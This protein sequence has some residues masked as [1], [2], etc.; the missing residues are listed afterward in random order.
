M[1]QVMTLPCTSSKELCGMR[2]KKIDDKHEQY[3]Y[4]NWKLV[5]CITTYYV[6]SKSGLGRSRLTY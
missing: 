5:L 1:V 4:W 6:P 3:V 2:V